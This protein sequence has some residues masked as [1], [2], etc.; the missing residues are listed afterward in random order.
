MKLINFIEVESLNNL[1]DSMKAKLVEIIATTNGWDALEDKLGTTGIDVSIDEIKTLPNGTLVYKNRIV[2]VYIRDWNFNSYSMPKYHIA[3]CSTLQEMRELN[4]INRYVVSNKDDGKF[5]VNKI[6][7]GVISSEESLDVCKNC[8]RHLNWN[9]YQ[10]EYE[11]SKRN[12]IFNDFTLRVFFEKYTKLLSENDFKYTVKSAPSND[13]PDDWDDI[14]RRKRES[15]NYTCE[16]CGKNM[17]SQKD[18]LDVHHI[19]GLKHDN[20]ES[21]LKV[22]CRW[23]HSEEPGHSHM[24]YNLLNLREH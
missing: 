15:K 6:K 4:K 9:G 13:Y 1:R 20:S 14:S 2:I 22:L 12:K 8:L 16:K 17:S 11:Y 18:K 24:K 7:N 23:C 3:N 10:D 21:N 19:N 5:V